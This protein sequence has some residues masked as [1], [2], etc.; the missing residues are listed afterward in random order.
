[1]AINNNTNLITI[2]VSKGRILD[3]S[4]ELLAEMGITVAKQDLD[5]RRLVL[6]TNKPEV[7][8]L[9][10]RATDVP[11]YVRHHRMRSNKWFPFASLKR[12]QHK[13]ARQ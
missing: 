7:R 11:T 2:A 3:E 6:P 10:I 9:I 13:T 1:M 4:L 8:L 5:G 12:H